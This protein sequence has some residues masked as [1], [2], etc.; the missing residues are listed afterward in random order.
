[1]LIICSGHTAVGRNSKDSRH[2]ILY[3]SQNETALTGSACVRCRQNRCAQSCNFCSA[4]RKIDT[5]WS[6]RKNRPGF[7]VLTPQFSLSSLIFHNNIKSQLLKH[8]TWSTIM[9]SSKFSTS[10]LVLNERHNHWPSSK[11]NKNESFHVH[12]STSSSFLCIMMRSEQRRELNLM[13]HVQW[14]AKIETMTRPETFNSTIDCPACKMA[15][16]NNGWLLLLLLFS[17][18]LIETVTECWPLAVRGPFRESRLHT[19]IVSTIIDFSI[20]SVCFQFFNGKIKKDFSCRP[21]LSA[22]FHPDSVLYWDNF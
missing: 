18:Q 17:I 13:K 15:G 20:C 14:G 6:L 21:E 8:S 10:Y 1:M 22:L 19:L 4:P 16:G 12:F 2:T 11:E 5:T 7:W 9:I 3:K